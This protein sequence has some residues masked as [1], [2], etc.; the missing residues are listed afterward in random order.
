MC[1]F[2]ISAL[3][4]AGLTHDVST[5]RP[6]SLSHRSFSILLLRAWGVCR[7]IERLSVSHTAADEL[8]P[9]RHHWDRI[10]LFWQQAPE[11]RVMPT[12]LVTAAVPVRADALPQML[13]LRD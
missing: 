7:L 1:K 13:D 11:C 9:F 10:C 5:G 3:I 4:P 12:K 8:R 6:A 2:L